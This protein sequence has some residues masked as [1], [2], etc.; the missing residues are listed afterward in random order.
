MRCVQILLFFCTSCLCFS[1]SYGQ[2]SANSQEEI[3]KSRER[4][5]KQTYT[6]LDIADFITG[7]I[8]Q[9]RNFDIEGSQYFTGEYF[10]NG[11][12][13]Y[14]GVLFENIPLQYDIYR[15]LVITLFDSGST[16]ENLSIDSNRISWFSFDGLKFVNY[17]GVLL[18]HGI[19]QEFYNGYR[20]TILIKRVKETARNDERSRY[21]YKFNTNYK[22]Y[23][24]IK[25]QVY[26]INKKKD[27]MIALGNDVEVRK[28]I[29]SNNLSFNRKM[30]EESLSNIMAYY[31]KI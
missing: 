19:Y 18:P 6:D 13:V 25:N 11:S 15:Q 1:L 26:Q 16:I 31:D 8:Y 9:L 5:V 22:I 3:T 2:H 12:L 29:K 7:K 30:I 14:D 17:K 21:Y 28:Y 23:L 4:N 20:S 10:V 24:L 27:L